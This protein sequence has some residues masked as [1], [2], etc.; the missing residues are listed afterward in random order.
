MMNN[1]NINYKKIIEKKLPRKCIKRRLWGP[2][3]TFCLE[4]TI[5][6][7]VGTTFL[8]DG[9]GIGVSKWPRAMSGRVD[10]HQS[11]QKEDRGLR[12]YVWSD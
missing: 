7:G 1:S 6:Q 5:S 10:H 4:G 3:D 12:G 2:T 11:G 9:V 8:G